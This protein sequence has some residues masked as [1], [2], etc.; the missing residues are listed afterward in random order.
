M[1]YIGIMEKKLETTM[2]YRGYIGIMGK[3]MDTTKCFGVVV[4]L[5]LASA[6]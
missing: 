6:I 5:G 3:K 4:H 1:G 2:V